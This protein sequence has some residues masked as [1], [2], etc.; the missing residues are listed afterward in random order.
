MYYRYKKFFL[1][2]FLSYFY[3]TPTF[4]N[5]HRPQDFLNSVAKSKEEGQEIVKHYC[6]VCHA[7]QPLVSIG[8]P[9]IGNMLDWQERLKQGMDKLFANASLGLNAMPARGGCF[10]CT[11]EQLMLAIIAMLPSNKIKQ[12]DKNI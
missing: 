1:V 5:T 9:K 4:S 7:E 2:V 6:V 11:D 10:E 12:K 3:L 8:A